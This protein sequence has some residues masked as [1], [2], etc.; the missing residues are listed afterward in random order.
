MWANAVTIEASMQ[1]QWLEGEFSQM[2]PRIY[3]RHPL[4]INLGRTTIAEEVSK[5]SSHFL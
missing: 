1:L 5:Q 2:K 4:N 3:K